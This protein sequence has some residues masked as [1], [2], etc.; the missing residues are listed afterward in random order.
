MSKN[1]R[2][3][4][5]KK[6]G[7]DAAVTSELLAV[8]ERIRSALLKWRR[9]FGWNQAQAAKVLGVGFRTL[10]R[11]EDTGDEALNPN[12]STLVR[13]AVELNMSV[14]VKKTK[15]ASKATQL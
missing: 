9:H 5:R 4:A 12:L 2:P 11:I 13:L 15:G 10:Q 14:F 8:R 1:L 3:P 6:P 7:H